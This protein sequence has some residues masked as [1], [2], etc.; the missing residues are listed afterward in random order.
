MEVKRAAIT[1]CTKGVGQA[2][3]TKTKI[4]ILPCGS[5]RRNFGA[6]ARKKATAEFVTAIGSPSFRGTDAAAAAAAATDNR[7]AEITGADVVQNC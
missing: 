1:N 5:G 4:S 2:T 7:R 3:L 6:V